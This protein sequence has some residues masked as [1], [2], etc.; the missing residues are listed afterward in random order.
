[1]VST[2]IIDINWSRVASF[3]NPFA[4]AYK[5]QNTFGFGF[6]KK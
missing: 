3:T 6:E 5:K 2:F 4:S 1:M